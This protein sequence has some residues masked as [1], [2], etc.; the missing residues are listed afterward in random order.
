MASFLWYHSSLFFCFYLLLFVLFFLLFCT[1]QSFAP[2]RFASS[3]LA[4]YILLPFLVCTYI[5]P[6]LES[7]C[8]SSL[9]QCVYIKFGLPRCVPAL[10]PVS[11]GRCW[12]D[13]WS[14]S[15]RGCIRNDGH[16]VR[17]VNIVS[18][19]LPPPICIHVCAYYLLSF[20]FPFG[21]SLNVLKW[22]CV[23]FWFS[24]GVLLCL[25]LASGSVAEAVRA[26]QIVLVI[27]RGVTGPPVSE[28]RREITRQFDDSGPAVE[29]FIH[30]IPGDLDVKGEWTL[31]PL[32]PK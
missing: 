11:P 17:L 32:F 26:D 3:L 16:L 2:H 28:L 7:A 14:D 19:N 31:L 8:A 21:F 4:R 6:P 25:L 5:F 29:P 23:S 30:V 24:L 22:K 10:S 27:L 18:H 9:P 15:R 13:S 20:L 12:A 1:I